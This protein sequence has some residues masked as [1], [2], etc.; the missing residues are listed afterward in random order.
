MENINWVGVGVYTYLSVGLIFCIVSI[1]RWN[2]KDTSR[3]HYRRFILCS[4]WNLLFLFSVFQMLTYVQLTYNFD[5]PFWVDLSV[6][7]SA[8]FIIFLLIEGHGYAG[9]VEDIRDPKN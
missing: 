9:P 6:L 8:F 2:A 3:K 7:V 1:V 4:L 5:A